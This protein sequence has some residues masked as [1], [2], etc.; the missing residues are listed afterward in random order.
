LT[1]VGISAYPFK[2]RKALTASR[3]PAATQR[4]RELERQH[5]ECFVE[6]FANALGGAG[7]LGPEPAR[8]I[9]QQSL[10]GFHVGGLIGPPEDRLGPRPIRALTQRRF[11]MAFARDTP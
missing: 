4:R 3:I 1:S 9:V 10:G 5:R 2:R 11:A 6:A 7:V 8:E